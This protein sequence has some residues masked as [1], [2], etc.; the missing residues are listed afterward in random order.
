MASLPL[1]APNN[2]R[3]SRPRP[4][5]NQLIRSTSHDQPA[6]AAADSN[7]PLPPPPATAAAETY[8]IPALRRKPLPDS[9]GSG[10]SKLNHSRS[11]SHPFP[12]IFGS[13]KL[14]KKNK[15]GG[16]FDGIRDSRHEEGGVKHPAAE[17]SIPQGN[18]QPVTG[19]CMT[20]D[21][22]VRWPQG[23]QVFR[24]TTCLTIN[25]LEYNPEKRPE[26]QGSAS[27]PVPQRKIVPMS[28]ERLRA[29][30]D[31]CL[32]QYLESRLEQNA[33]L[34]PARAMP[35]DNASPTEDSY[36]L[37]GT[38]PEG[39]LYGH[40]HDFQDSPPSSPRVVA[41]PRSPSEDST[42]STHRPTRNG[43]FVQGHSTDPFSVQGRPIG[44][45]PLENGPA[46][47]SG[48]RS[49]IFRLVENY[50]GGC[51]VGCATLNHSF[52]T[53]RPPQEPKARSDWGH[54][55]DGN[56]LNPC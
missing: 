52:L 14:D 24:C 2:H 26:L 37:E 11:F 22:T 31:R 28:V 19:K 44:Q 18:R 47:T 39:V 40:I 23:L 3:P 21:S 8:E 5:N 9:P 34:T 25:D 53:P 33:P 49:D 12:S 7:R 41:N 13:K 51:F 38:L 46:S 42:L 48:P 17:S 30:I 16:D 50:V 35:V 45:P 27:G 36:L 1:S 43:P 29:L 20:C 10:A 4:R 54:N 55:K 15:H 6:T 56:G 32:R